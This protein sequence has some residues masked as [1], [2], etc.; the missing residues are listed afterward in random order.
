MFS[1]AIWDKRARK[2]FCARDRLGKKPFYYYW[3]GRLFA[4]ASEIKALLRHPAISPRFEESLLPEYL[5]FGYCQRRADAL[6]RHPQAHAGPF[7]ILRPG[8]CASRT[9]NPRILGYSRVL[10]GGEDRD[11]ASWIHR[12]PRAV[13][14]RP[15]ALRL[16]SDVPL[17]MFL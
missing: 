1:F 14:K 2:L 5:A 3:D 6:L 15:S 9:A 13:W 7:L 8:L 17:G 10:L 12:M 16:M 11:D 4:F